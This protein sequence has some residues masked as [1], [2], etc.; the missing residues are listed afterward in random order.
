MSVSTGFFVAGGTLG[1]GAESYVVRQADRDLIEV[2][3]NREFA[4]VL[5]SRQK[6][7]SSLMI[8][9]RRALEEEGTRTVLL[10]LQRF[11]SNLDPERWYAS[12][13][14]AVDESLDA[15]DQLFGAW[16]ADRRLGP[17]RRFFN[18]IEDLLTE[19]DLRVVV[20]VDEVDF[21]RSLP[22]S[23]DEFFA[24]IRECHNRSATGVQSHLTFC[25][26]GVANPSEL[27]HDVRITPFNIGRRIELTDFTLAEL[28]PFHEPLSEGGR[29]GRL[30]TERVHRWTGG[31]PYLTQRLAAAVAADPTIRSGGGVDRLAEALFL[32]TKARTEEPN[33][34]DAS[35][36]ML[37]APIEGLH[38]SESRS[39]VLDAYLAVLEGR[40]PVR[41][42][43]TDPVVSVLKL[44]GLV[45]VVDGRLAIRNQVYRRAFDRAWAEANLPEAERK[46]VQSAARRA[47][48][49]VIGI[50]GLVTLA[51][52]GI[53]GYAGFLAIQRREALQQLRVVADRSDRAAYNAQ[54]Y[55]L[56]TE[57]QKSNWIRVIEILDRLKNSMSKG[58]EF[59]HWTRVAEQGR[60]VGEGS[61]VGV[62]FISGSHDYVLLGAG[63]FETSTG[64]TYTLKQRSRFLDSAFNLRMPVG[65][66]EISNG[67]LAAYLEQAAVLS[68]PIIAVGKRSGAIAVAEDKG[69]VRVEWPDRLPTR[70]YL[71]KPTLGSPCAAFSTDETI[72]YVSSKDEWLGCYDLATARQ[73]WRVH[74]PK[75]NY[76]DSSPDNRLLAVASEQPRV[77]LLDAHDGHMIREL[78]GHS[79]FVNRVRFAPGG[80]WF[81]SAGADGVILLW[82][83]A[84]GSLMRSLIGHRGSV[85]RLDISED[86]K[87]I[88]SVSAAREVM[89]WDLDDRPARDALRVH[90]DKVQRIEVSPDGKRLATSSRDKTSALVDLG[91]GKVIA[92]LQVGEPRAAHGL[93]FSLNGRL[94]AVARTDG[95]IL[96][97]DSASGTV[98]RE[99]SYHRQD[100]RSLTFTR[101]SKRLLSVSDDGT[102][103]VWT[104]ADG[105]MKALTGHTG[106]V[107][108]GAM[109]PNGDLCATAS[110]DGS[111][112]LW[113]AR[114]AAPIRTW[115]LAG[116]A[117]SVQFS[118]DGRWIVFTGFDRFLRVRDL[119]KD[120][121]PIVMR[122]HTNRVYEA[123]FSPDG[124]RVLS[125]SAD[126]TAR[127]W[128][129]R[130]GA[131]IAVLRHSSWVSSAKFSDDGRRIVTTANDGLV[132]IWDAE[133]GDQIS[134]LTGH[135]DTPFDSQWIEGG[136]TLITCGDDA[137]IRFWRSVRR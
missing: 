42:D 85:N 21:V 106:G 119:S 107:R 25:L 105:S 34:S 19:R 16:D 39:R 60:L 122:G 72:L 120:D 77:L 102:A 61:F 49:Q 136:K 128:D 28:E 35:R 50:A 9:V 57:A 3:R 37:E 75:A 125:N 18:S 86:D 70:F 126:G 101:D 91:S 11:G 54:M 109:S 31:H 131:E 48:A 108:W 127:L 112:R 96:I 135:T 67:S 62:G 1:Q 95:T 6:G 58:W 24:G 13:L 121:P 115:K 118:D 71:G 32:G 56:S 117:T 15:S 10:D 110:Q 100:V 87:A 114:S 99:L 129:A 66:K 74:V 12:L 134:A 55:V 43:D 22:F 65:S 68:L 76:I 63:H 84:D 36:R 104:V 89:F 40:R 2:L 41:D 51:F 111:V 82:N 80:K 94:L 73:R 98:E 133:T 116:A 8:R 14:D 88:V 113:N 124:L 5:D 81:A 137:A 26:L 69:W 27:I 93:A 103:A 132:A 44:S 53:A 83:T 20:F 97:V 123:R 33:L 29:D 4:Y 78:S 90:R 17:M 64:E 30:L 59:G 38:A 92:R 46:R 23:V 47:R 45:K 79:G 52:A 130:T 7:K